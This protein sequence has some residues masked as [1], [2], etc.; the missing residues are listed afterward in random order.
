MNNYHVFCQEC[1]HS[2]YLKNIDNIH[3]YVGK[4]VCYICKSKEVTIQK[5][6]EDI[7][8]NEIPSKRDQDILLAQKSVPPSGSFLDNPS[9]ITG[10]IDANPMS[11]GVRDDDWDSDNWESYI[12]EIPDKYFE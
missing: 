2:A 12:S 5:D 8:E 6:L 1:T 7:P 10:S 3:D 4:L 9:P 11:E